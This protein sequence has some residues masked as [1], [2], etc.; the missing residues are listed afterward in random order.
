MNPTSDDIDALPRVAGHDSCEYPIPVDGRVLRILGP[1]DPTALLD[2]PRVEK[3]NETDGYMPYWATPWPSAVMLAEFALREPTPAGPILEIAAGLGVV[4]LAMSRAGRRVIITDYDEDALA[5]V[6]A[7]AAR[8]AIVPFNVMPLDWRRP[9][10][11]Q[12]DMIVAAD[13]LYETRNLKEVVRLIKACLAA[14]GLALVSD[15]NRS[16]AE[17]FPRVAQDAGLT[18]EAICVSCRAIPGLDSSEGRAVE[19]T[20]YRIAQDD[21]AA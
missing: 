6:R 2:C 10:P 11:E 15:Q 12:Y 21:P 9:P 20:V 19:G 17:G 14:G 8:N 1:L 7:S 5:F 4:G 16:T 3:R 18:C 13:V